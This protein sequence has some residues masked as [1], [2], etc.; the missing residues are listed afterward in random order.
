MDYSPMQVR[1]AEK[2]RLQRKIT[3]C[4][5][6]QGNALDIRFNNETFDA[7]VSIGSIKHWPDAHKGLKEICRILKPG[8]CLI[9]SETDQE[10]SDD[11]IRQF[12]GRF[13][14]WFIPDWLLF[15][16]LRHVIFGQSYSETTLAA[17]ALTAGFRNVE[18]QRVPTCPYVIVKAQK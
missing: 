4:S 14:I 15:W 7:A 2:Y 12:I 17:A 8:G 6:Q 1:E 13:K 11:A 18:C 9:I 16:G 5:F 10:A 3:N